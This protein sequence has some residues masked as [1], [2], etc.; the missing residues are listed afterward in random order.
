MCQNKDH[1]LSELAD[2]NIQFTKTLIF[3]WKTRDTGQPR[4]LA[5]LNMYDKDY[6]QTTTVNMCFTSARNTIVVKLID[7]CITKANK[8]QF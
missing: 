6:V 7:I 3:P 4:A 2:T 1:P 8:L 5:D